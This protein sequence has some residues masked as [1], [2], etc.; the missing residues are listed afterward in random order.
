LRKA[1]K[2]AASAVGDSLSE[3]NLR[4]QDGMK[5]KTSPN[6][7][8]DF[9]EFECCDLNESFVITKKLIDNEKDRRI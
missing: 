1:F 4:N 9:Y 8:F 6:G 7:H 2:N 5:T 3:G